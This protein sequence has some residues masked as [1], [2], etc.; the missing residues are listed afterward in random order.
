ME[1]IIVRASFKGGG[2]EGGLPP[3]LDEIL[4]P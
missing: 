4:P 1:A 2:G 3:P